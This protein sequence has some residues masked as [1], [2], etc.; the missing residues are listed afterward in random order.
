MRN[1][2]ETACQQPTPGSLYETVAT[3][4]LEPESPTVYHEGADLLIDDHPSQ[5]ADVGALS[6]ELR[7]LILLTLLAALN[8]G[9]CYRRRS[10]TLVLCGTLGLESNLFFGKPL[11]RIHQ[12]TQVILV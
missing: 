7:R 1:V 9:E 3:P 4:G 5:V 8:E 12:A 6:I 10:P 11:S 2:R